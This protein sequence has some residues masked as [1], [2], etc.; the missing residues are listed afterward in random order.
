M[1]IHRNSLDYVGYTCPVVF[2][3]LFDEVN[4][5]PFQA[6]I[7]ASIE[8]KE[9]FGH[10]L[11]DLARLAARH[12]QNYGAEVVRE[13]FD[14]ALNEAYERE[15]NLESEIHDLKLRIALLE[16]GQNNGS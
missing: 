6:Y 10:W 5:D 13:A 12:A 14:R 16:K 7:Q 3:N 15:L 4:C 9:P 1:A 11:R 8:R 2:D